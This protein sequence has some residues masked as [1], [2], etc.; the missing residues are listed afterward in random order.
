MA[1]DASSQLM[2]KKEE[3]MF[4]GK[5]R[6]ALESYVMAGYGKGW[7]RRDIIT[8]SSWN[9]VFQEGDTRFVMEVD[10]FKNF[11][12]SATFSSSHCVL[13]SYIVKSNESLS[14][15]IE[16]GWNII[17]HKR[18]ALALKMGPGLTLDIATNVTTLP[19]MVAAELW[20]GLPQFLCPVS[21]ESE[22]HIQDS[23]CDGS[24]K[25]KILRVGFFGLAPIIYGKYCNERIFANF[26][27]FLL[28]WQEMM[29]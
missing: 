24:L 1:N 11:D 21:G 9:P 29:V 7:T 27:D 15:L 8:D 26:S 25:D 23:I 18:L 17:Q 13:M 3:S 20:N 5:H 16:I 14:A 22:P 19:F 2:A 4:M 12:I 10:Q 6:G 28:A